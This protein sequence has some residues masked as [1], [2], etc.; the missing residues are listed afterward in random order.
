MAHVACVP[1]VSHY[2]YFALRFKLEIIVDLDLEYLQIDIC[3][4]THIFEIHLA[5]KMLFEVT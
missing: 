5:K 4:F 3:I 2:Y 1:C